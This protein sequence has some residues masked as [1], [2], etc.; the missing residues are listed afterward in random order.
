M[1]VIGVMSGSSLDGI[2]LAHG[3]FVEGADGWTVT[4]G[5]CRTVPYD[6][7]LRTR[8]L[9]ATSATA[10]ELARLHRDVGLAI[11]RAAAALAS[12]QAAELVASHGHT[13]F[14][15]P[16]EG[17][18]LQIGCGAHIAKHA[19]LPVACDFRTGDVALGGHGAPLVPL[20]E[21]L[22]FPGRKAFI[23][24]GGIC[25]LA[26][27]GTARTIGFDVCIGNQALDHL[28]AEAGMP[29]DAEGQMARS[30]RVLPQLLT[31]L[32][33]LP[34]HAQ[35]PPR[36]L[37]R[38]WFETEVRPLLS[39]P[40][41]ALADRMC[42]VVEH[43]AGQLARQLPSTSRAVLVTGGGAHHTYLIERL[44]ALSSVPVEV[45]ERTLVDYKEALIFGLLGVLRWKGK[46]TALASV[47]G[48]RMDSVGGAVYL[49]N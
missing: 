8:L 44:R 42:T 11:G 32:N 47:T 49:P 39:A 27:H 15:Q 38:E 17:L 26:L 24:I 7:A 21:A 37:G 5:I 41:L 19:G 30:G 25:N 36:S 10:L 34:F 4:I 3:T 12:E 16:A 29:Y 43:I 35:A 13:I 1:K 48:A 28:A 31:A 9:H 14:H 18:T 2:D 40:D 33:D 23:N 46:P 20:G 45:P 22:L 6:P